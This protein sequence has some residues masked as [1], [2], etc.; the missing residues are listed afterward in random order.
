M[1]LWTMIHGAK[2]WYPGFA[3]LVCVSPGETGAVRIAVNYRNDLFRLLYF[4]MVNTVPSFLHTTRIWERHRPMTKAT[5]LKFIGQATC[6]CIQFFPTIKIT[7]ICQLCVYCGLSVKINMCETC[8][9]RCLKIMV[10]WMHFVRILN[11]CVVSK[12]TN[13]HSPIGASYS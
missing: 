5:P 1:K 7:T 6:T 2:K 9:A 8:T 3:A 12:N 4:N 10:S 11:A 13:T